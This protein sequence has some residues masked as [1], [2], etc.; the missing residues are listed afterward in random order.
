MQ[1]VVVWGFVM[2]AMSVLVFHQ[3]TIHLL[4]NYGN[5]VPA[6]NDWI[7]QVGG[8]GWNL[9]QGMANPPIPG[10]HIPN[11]FNQMFW[12]GLWGI[13]IAALIRYTT[14]PDLLTGA[15]VGGF[16]CVLVAVTVVASL[17]GFPLFAGGD[18]RTLL[19]AVLIN[20][21]FGFGV[22]F[23]LRPIQVRRIP[24]ERLAATPRPAMR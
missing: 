21:G 9:N 6:M 10:L 8:P 7:G 4:Y 18:T 12:G 16:G 13:L 23:L 5:N 17:K 2:G 1:K 20:G 15:V 14:L 22:A 24:I 3:G 11:F 19:R